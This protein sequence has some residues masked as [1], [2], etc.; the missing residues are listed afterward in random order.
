MQPGQR[1]PARDLDRAYDQRAHPT[2]NDTQ[3]DTDSHP[4]IIPTPSTLPRFATLSDQ[5]A[6]EARLEAAERLYLEEV[7]PSHDGTEGIR[8]FIE[9]RPAV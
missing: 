8:A 2:N 9:K 7:L 6:I 4:N 1:H 3:T 5:A